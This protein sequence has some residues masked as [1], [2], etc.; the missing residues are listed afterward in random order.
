[1]GRENEYYRS[2]RSVILVEYLAHI[3]R[4]ELRNS[5]NNDNNTILYQPA[6]VGV[7]H[8]DI[9]QNHRDDEAYGKYWKQ[10][11]EQL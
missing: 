2:H 8:R 5:H 11:H 7:T 9:Y 10:E 6:S 4:S 3:M 1:M